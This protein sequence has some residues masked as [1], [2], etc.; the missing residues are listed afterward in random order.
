MSGEDQV[1]GDDITADNHRKHGGGV[2]LE[3]MLLFVIEHAP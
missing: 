3:R 1:Y 2:S